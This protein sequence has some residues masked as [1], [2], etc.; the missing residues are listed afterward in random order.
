MKDYDVQDAF[1]YN[2]AF[3]MA[4]IGAGEAGGRIVETF[5]GLGYR[6]LAA[7]NGGD[8]INQL[9]KEI[10][11]LDLRTGGAGKDPQ[12]GAAQIRDRDEEIFELMTR[13][14]GKDP[15]FILVCA[16]FGGGTGGGAAPRLID[17]ARQYMEDRGKD[18][19]RVGAIVTLPHHAEG[20]TPCRNAVTCFKQLYEKRPSPL[21]IIDNLRI[22]ELAPDAEKGWRKI[23]RYANSQVAKLFHLFNRFAA[24]RSKILTFDRA[25]F[26]S[27]LD[28]GICVF[29]ASAIST[30]ESPADISEAIRNQ[31]ATTVLAQVNL[32]EGQKAGCLFVGS[33][34]ILD[35]VPVEFFDGGFTMLTRLLQE[36]SVVH[37]GVYEGS[38]TD[39]R[40]YTMLAGLPAPSERLKKLASAG[41][42][43]GQGTASFLGVDDGEP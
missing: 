32:K 22:G 29:G 19:A 8:E 31:L 23:Y 18:P 15:D 11:A 41:G 1:G 7:I 9:P 21:L 40:C 4:F 38:Q 16:G 30:Y 43:A 14:F 3:N 33:P 25:D 12:L 2:T 28:S 37:R 10:A 35:S 17:I 36:N 24:T 13:G 26:A 20:F 27:L 39:L 5:Y 34:E 6:R 42:L